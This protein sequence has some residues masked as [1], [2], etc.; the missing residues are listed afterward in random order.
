MSRQEQLTSQLT[1][2]LADVNYRGM[3]KALK[4]L[5]DECGVSVPGKLNCRKREMVA[6]ATIVTSRL[7]ASQIPAVLF[8]GESAVTRTLTDLANRKRGKNEAQMRAIA[9]RVNDLVRV[10][11]WQSAAYHFRL[12]FA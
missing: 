9:A 4:G 10:G 5:R 2:A 6:I 11:Q 7:M 8:E 1:V 3:Q 12:A